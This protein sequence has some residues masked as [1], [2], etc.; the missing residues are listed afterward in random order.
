MLASPRCAC[1]SVV[2]ERDQ[3]GPPAAGAQQL[4][5]QQLDPLPGLERP[6]RVR[7]VGQQLAR[8]QRQGRLRGGP[9]PASAARAAASKAVT[10]TATSRPGNS[11]TISLRKDQRVRRAGRPAG[12]VR[13][14]VEL[15]G[16]GPGLRVRPQRV[17]HPFAVQP[18]SRREREQLDQPRRAPPGER[19]RADVPAVDLD[20]EAA[21]QAHG[22]RHGRTVAPDQDRSGRSAGAEQPAFERGGHGGGAVTHP[23]FRVRVEQ[24]RLHGGLADEQPPRRLAVGTTLRD[25]REHLELA[26]AERFLRG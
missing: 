17:H 6:G 26:L 19:V 10:S 22:H 8:A 23:Q 1:S 11:A 15:V 14:L 13:R 5:A 25:Q 24:M 18:A 3:L 7:L 12:V 20:G 9:F 21:E 4:A 2:V 16:G